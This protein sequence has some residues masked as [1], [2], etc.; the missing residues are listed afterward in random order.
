MLIRVTFLIRCN[1][2]YVSHRVKSLHSSV[3]LHLA[4]I[5]WFGVFCVAC[6]TSGAATPPTTSGVAPTAVGGVTTA[7]QP[8]AT[9][10]NETNTVA[11]LV[12]QGGIDGS[13]ITTT[14]MLDRVIFSEPSQEIAVDAA[15]VKALQT[16]LEATG[17]YTVSPGSYLPEQQCCDRYTYYLTLFRAGTTYMYTTMDDTPTA[18]RSVFA[19]IEAVD[20]FAAHAQ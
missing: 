5:L 14:V 9:G 20:A 15:K 18:P 3:V 13:T 4:S 8:T 7:P 6:G 10:S 17:I 19:A 12:R 1:T 16:Q 11:V 2:L